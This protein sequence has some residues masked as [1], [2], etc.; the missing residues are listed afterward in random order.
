ML[1]VLVLVYVANFV[2]R[3]V[4]SILNE[5]IKRDLGLG[6]GEMGF[7]YGTAFAVFYA[8]FGIPLGRLADLWVRRSLIAVSLGIWS[9]MTVLAGLARNFGELAAARIGVGVGE[10]GASPAAFSILSDNY[11]PAR[12]A[13]ALEIYSSGIY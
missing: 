11:P 7:L 6:D 13:T 2:D 12:R 9:T 3:Q 5:E 4:L 10:A 1:G 8:L